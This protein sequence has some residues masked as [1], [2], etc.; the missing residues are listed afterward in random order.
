MTWVCGIFR[1]TFLWI[2]LR[3][4]LRLVGRGILG[5]RGGLLGVGVRAEDET[6]LAVNGNFPHA[7]L[8]CIAR[9]KRLAAGTHSGGHVFSRNSYQ[10][11]FGLVPGRVGEVHWIVFHV[12]IEVESL[13]IAQVG[14]GDGHGDSGQVGRLYASELG[15][16][17]ARV[18][19]VAVDFRVSLFPGEF[20]ILRAGVGHDV[21]AAEGIEV[22]IVTG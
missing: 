20:V 19:V 14:V 2:V 13:R 22:G 7:G 1:A 3:L 21:L 10:G 8:N 17:V 4:I 9:A 5:G 12:R 18:N 16:V 15:G 11:T 6:G